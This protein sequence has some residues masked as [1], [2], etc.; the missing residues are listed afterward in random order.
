MDELPGSTLESLPVE[1][2]QEILSQL[3]DVLSLRSAVLT[4]PCLYHIHKDADE[5]ITTQVLLQHLNLDLICEAIAAQEA[6]SHGKSPWS[7]PYTLEF[8]ERHY[9]PLHPFPHPRTSRWKLSEAIPMARLYNH[10]HHFAQG[11]ISKA[12][13]KHPVSHAPEPT[14][15]PPSSIEINRFERNLYR[16]ETYRHIFGDPRTLPLKTR[17][18]QNAVC[19]EQ[20]ALYWN[21]FSPWENEQLAC[22]YDYLM[23]AVQPG[24]YI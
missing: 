19:R 20:N 22:V 16:F 8:L 12:L 9:T 1:I 3:D 5:S 17:E 24:N 21:R 11:M 4:G 6:A 2:L 7:K 10:I 14:P 18:E 23:G 15:T 13:A